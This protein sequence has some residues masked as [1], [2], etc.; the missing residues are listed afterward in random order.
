MIEI[1]LYLRI[2]LFKRIVTGFLTLLI[3]F[4]DSGQMIYGHTCL[5]SKRTTISFFA[6]KDC[7]AKREIKKSCCS[8][9]AEEKKTCAFGKMSCCSISAKYVKQSFPTDQV[10]LPTNKIERQIALEIKLFSAYA[11]PANEITVSH[12]PVPLL[13]CKDDIRFTQ[14]FRI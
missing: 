1:I 6:N 10:K 4:A 8:K 13:R 9:K 7:C 14:V 11:A 5:K 2:M 12:S 3:L